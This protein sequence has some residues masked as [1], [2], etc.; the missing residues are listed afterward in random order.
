[1]IQCNKKDYVQP[2]THVV[3]IKVEEHI[4]TGSALIDDMDN[5]FVYDDL[6]NDS[7]F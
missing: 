3:A 4:L 5:E 7:L 2:N 1:M 6:F